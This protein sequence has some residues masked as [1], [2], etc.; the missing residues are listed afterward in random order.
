MWTSRRQSRHIQNT[1]DHALLTVALFLEECALDLS[2][3]KTVYLPFTRKSLRDFKLSIARREVKRVTR[4][5]FVGIT[6]T[7]D[8]NWKQ[9]IKCLVG[10][11]NKYVNIMRVIAGHRWGHGK[12]LQTVHRGLV[13]KTIAHSIPHLHNLSATQE[14]NLQRALSRSLRVVFGIPKAARTDLVLMEARKLPIQVLRKQETERHLIRLLTKHTTHPLVEKLKKRHKT[15]WH[16]ALQ[17]VEKTLPKRRSHTYK[18]DTAPWTLTAS[19]VTIDIPGIQNKTDALTEAL[20]TLSLSHL[21][22]QYPGSTQV[23]ADGSCAELHALLK[24]FRHIQNSPANNWV[25]CSDSKAALETLQRQ[26]PIDIPAYEISKANTSATA[27]GHIIRVQWVPS[28]CGIPGNEV[29]DQTDKDALTKTRLSAVPFAK[30]DTK[31]FL[32]KNTIRR[33]RRVWKESL[34]PENY[35]SFIDPEATAFIPYDIT[36]PIKTAIHR[37]RLGAMFTFF[38]LL[39]NDGDLA[40]EGTKHPSP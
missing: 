20:R 4:H 5:K 3:D 23:H 9:H 10:R 12:A 18:Q 28:H 33:A 30:S 8:L 7:R 24:V 6:I 26:D 1:L 38:L 2:I 39:Q 22:E 40:E 31:A 37:A 35:L 11:T 17:F 15:S 16:K 13:R 19:V 21:D 27:K 36:R 32:R 14:A 25:I 34:R 29:P